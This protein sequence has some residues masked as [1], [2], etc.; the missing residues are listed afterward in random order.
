MHCK[1]VNNP[2]YRTSDQLVRTRGDR[3]GLRGLM[4][5][6]RVTGGKDRER[7]VQGGT[8]R[9]IRSRLAGGAGGVP[10]LEVGVGLRGLGAART[11]VCP[12][13]MTTRGWDDK[14]TKASA[15]RRLAAPHCATGIANVPQL[16]DAPSCLTYGTRCPALLH[17]CLS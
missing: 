16:P 14:G 4:G 7:Q 15:S 13:G 2:P 6:S 17:C 5:P 12:D 11:G 10:C 8:S 9:G 3:A 1:G